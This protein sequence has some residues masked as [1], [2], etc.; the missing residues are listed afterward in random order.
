MGGKIVRTIGLIRATAKIGRMNLVYNISR[1]AFLEPMCL[2]GA[3]GHA[4]IAGERQL[5]SFTTRA[6]IAAEGP[7]CQGNLARPLETNF[8]QNPLSR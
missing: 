2:P 6:P 4:R 3:D 1:C 7:L 5:H 8:R